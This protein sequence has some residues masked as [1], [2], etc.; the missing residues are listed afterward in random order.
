M[1]GGDILLEIP[2]NHL[3]CLGK[4]HTL[5]CERTEIFLTNFQNTHFYFLKNALIF[6]NVFYAIFYVDDEVWCEEEMV[7]PGVY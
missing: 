7:G 3:V 4:K 6:G 5:L 1:I 2:R